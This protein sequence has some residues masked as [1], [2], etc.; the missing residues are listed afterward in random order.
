MVPSHYEVDEIVCA[1]AFHQQ[2]L[3]LPFCLRYNKLPIHNIEITAI[4]LWQKFP[5][6]KI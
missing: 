6:T 5:F 4:I 1:A 2:N 3:E